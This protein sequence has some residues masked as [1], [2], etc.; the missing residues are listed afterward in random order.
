MSFAC[1]LRER[2]GTLDRNATVTTITTTGGGG[3]GGPHFG[4]GGVG[5][6]VCVTVVSSPF[7]RGTSNRPRHGS[8]LKFRESGGTP[9][10]APHQHP[11]PVRMDGFGIG[12]VTGGEGEEGTITFRVV[13]SVP[14][15]TGRAASS[16]TGSFRARTRCS[17]K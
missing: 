15:E 12:G 16:V 5:W 11:V 6:L 8:G 2:S 17:E 13:D 14:G 9:P 7:V 3:H 1:I 4:V 10:T